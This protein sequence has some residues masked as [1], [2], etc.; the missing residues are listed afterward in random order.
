[1]KMYDL[2][3]YK[4]TADIIKSNEAALQK[5]PKIQTLEGCAEQRLV[6]LT[7]YCTTNQGATYKSDT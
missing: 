6:Q 4:M 5:N 2:M 1:M 3:Q 7:K